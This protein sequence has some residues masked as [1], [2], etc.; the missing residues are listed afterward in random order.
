LGV[1]NLP[2]PEEAKQDY[3]NE[4]K[5]PARKP[6]GTCGHWFY[7]LFIFCAVGII[8]GSNRAFLMASNEEFH[9]MGDFFLARFREDWDINAL[10]FARRYWRYFAVLKYFLRD[11]MFLS[12]AV[13]IRLFLSEKSVLNT[14]GCAIAVILA[15]GFL[16]AV[17][18]GGGYYGIAK[19][20]SVW[21]VV[22]GWYQ[23]LKTRK[24]YQS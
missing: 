9:L 21:L 11:A 10:I 3:G 17:L 5:P 20:I 13:I 2:A 16:C 24:K 4:E 14:H 8:D 19:N 18:S 22:F 1:E 6:V 15:L 7:I 12:P 23:I